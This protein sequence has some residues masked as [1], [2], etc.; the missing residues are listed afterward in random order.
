MVNDVI[1]RLKGGSIKSVVLFADG[2]EVPPPPCVVVRTESG[3]VRGTRSIR[4]VV[5][6]AQGNFDA[7]NE[8]V[9]RELDGL[10]AGGFDGRGGGRYKLYPN[11]FTDVTPDPDG[12]C[13]FMERIYL[14]PVLGLAN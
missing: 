3:V 4:I 1:D 14:A 12:G 6:H 11:G 10:L 9:T 7:L 2:M 8:Y 13:V 5:R